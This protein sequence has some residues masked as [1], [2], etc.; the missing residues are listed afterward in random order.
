MEIIAVE[1]FN[2]IDD[3]NAWLLSSASGITAD[4]IINIQWREPMYCVYYR[5][6]APVKRSDLAQGIDGEMLWN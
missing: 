6:Q 4:K 2:T 1:Y 3:L 5:K